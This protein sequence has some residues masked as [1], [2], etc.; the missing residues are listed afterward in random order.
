MLGELWE[1]GHHVG[2]RDRRSSE[3]L[4]AKIY[5]FTRWVHMILPRRLRVCLQQVGKILPILVLVHGL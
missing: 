4:D 1:P 5:L 2:V 3:K